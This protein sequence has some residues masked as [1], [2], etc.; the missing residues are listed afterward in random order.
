MRALQMQV[1][2]PAG[3]RKKKKRCDV[4]TPAETPADSEMSEDSDASELLREAPF[5]EESEENPLQ[6]NWPSCEDRELWRRWAEYFRPNVVVLPPRG[7]YAAPG[8]DEP[9]GPE[10]QDEETVVLDH[11][12]G[13][14]Y[15]QP[16]P[17]ELLSTWVCEKCGFE[18][19]NQFKSMLCSCCRD[20]KGVYGRCGQPTC[21]ERYFLPLGFDDRDFGCLVCH[22]DLVPRDV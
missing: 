8:E 17:D 4:A 6:G 3:Q 12:W 22:R 1:F 13:R 18:N 2:I 10:E 5:P 9:F 19:T 11:N 20:G 15:H 14:R 16:A 7:G 21:R